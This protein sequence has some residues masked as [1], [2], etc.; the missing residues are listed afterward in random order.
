MVKELEILNQWYRHEDQDE[1]NHTQDSQSLA[2]GVKRGDLVKRL[3]VI[4]SKEEDKGSPEPPATPH[5]TQSN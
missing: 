4:T 1:D 5:Q 3:S 2:F